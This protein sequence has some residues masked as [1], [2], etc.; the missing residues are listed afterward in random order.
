MT[1]LTLTSPPR[2]PANASYKHYRDWLLFNFYNHLCSYCLLQ[3]EG[4]QI[5]HY[6]PK[7]F[8][9]QRINDPANLLL[10]CNR[11]N[12]GKSDYHAD[13]L[14]RRRCAR[15]THAHTV[16]DVRIDDFAVLYGMKEDGA[17][18]VNA[19]PHQSR[20][21]WNALLLRLDLPFP[22]K[23]RADCLRALQLCEKLIVSASPENTESASCI[24]VLV[25]YCAEQYL[26]LKAF[27]IPISACLRERLEKHIAHHSSGVDRS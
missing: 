8:T 12:L 17:L 7:S 11:C 5:E 4:L 3:Q 16:I 20:A 1:R 22:N 24:E 27:D 18:H 13:F 26:L 15:E 21:E 9:P 23:K 10:A 2:L 19:G 25:R 14:S 6:E